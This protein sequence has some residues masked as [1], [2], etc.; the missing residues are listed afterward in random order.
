VRSDR[1]LLTFITLPTKAIKV[2]LSVR[3]LF[4]EVKETKQDIVM[5]V[6]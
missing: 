3:M 1:L 4:D 2:E 6:Y 5:D